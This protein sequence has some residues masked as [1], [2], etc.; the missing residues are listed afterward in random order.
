MN[1]EAPKLQGM[2]GGS[3]PNQGRTIIGE[4]A[5]AAEYFVIEL[6]RDDPTSCLIFPKFL[7]RV[8]D[9]IR[10]YGSDADPIWMR[11][12]VFNAFQD[13]SPDC[14]LLAALNDKTEIIAHA[15]VRIDLIE[16]R[17]SAFIV[18]VENNSRDPAIM[19]KGLELIENW[20]KQKGL[21]SLSNMALNEKVMRLW[22]IKYG[23]KNLRWLMV[24]PS[25]EEE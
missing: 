5:S 6:R 11:Q 19:E 4:Y 3:Q 2:N 13:R 7:D 1:L 18:Q 9:F 8:V 10:L 21:K 16:Q 20:R 15:I 25:G 24:R 17:P 14:L 23:F 12:A 22:K